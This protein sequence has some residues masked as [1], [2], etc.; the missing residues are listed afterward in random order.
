MGASICQAKDKGISLDMVGGREGR[1]GEVPGENA[2][3]AK[4]TSP[5]HEEEL[6]P[7]PPQELPAGVE[8]PAQP[9]PMVV[10]EL[11]RPIPIAVCLLQGEDTVGQ[12]V[13]K[14]EMGTVI[15]PISEMASPLKECRPGDHVP[16]IRRHW[17]TKALREGVALVVGTC[18]AEDQF[19]IQ[20]VD[21]MHEPLNVPRAALW[22][23]LDDMRA[24]LRS[25]H[26][27]ECYFGKCGKFSKRKMLRLEPL[28]EDIAWG[29]WF[30]DGPPG[31]ATRLQGGA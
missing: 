1:E 6:S 20:P 4:Q 18:D 10:E 21:C 3:D 24:F 7:H 17:D 15:L 13:G 26:D 27:R 22:R 19:M 9:I 30:S 29:R 12:T 8:E 23:S 14:D 25:F 28:L 2:V 11:V 16:I 31:G 5:A